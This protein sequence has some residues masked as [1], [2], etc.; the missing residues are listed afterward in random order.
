MNVEVQIIGVSGVFRL[1]LKE[2]DYRQM[3]ASKNDPSAKFITF[4]GKNLVAGTSC[5]MD[6]NK[7]H[8][9]F[10]NSMDEDAVSLALPPSGMDLLRQR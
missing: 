2:E 10:I 6:V 4:D 1:H 8:I 5:V 7:D 3:Q 9:I